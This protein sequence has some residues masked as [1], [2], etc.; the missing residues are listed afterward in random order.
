MFTPPSADLFIPSPTPIQYPV[1]VHSSLGRPVYSFTNSNSVSNPCSLLPRQTCLFLHQLQFSIQS[2]FTPPSADLFIPSPTP[3]QYPVHVHSSLGRPVY[4]FTNSNSVSSPCSLLPR[5]TCLFLHQLQFSIQSIFTP[6]SADLFI[7]SPTPIQYP[8]H[9]QSMFTPPSADLFIPSPT[10]IQYPVHVHSS[11]GRPVYSFT[12]SNSVSSPCSLLP[13]QTC[14]FLHQ[15]QFSIQSM[16]TPP[17]ADLFIPSPTPIQYPVH[18]HS[19]LGRPVYS[20]T[21][22]NSVSSP[23]SLLPRQTC[24]FL[25]QLQFSIQSMFTPPSA[26][27]FIPSPTPIQYPVHVH[28]SLGRPVYSFTNSNSVS[29]PCSL[30]PQQT[31]LFLHQ[32][33][34]SIQSMFTPPSA[35][36]FIPSPTPIQYPVHVHSFLGR[37]VYSFTNSNSVSSP[38]SL[39]PQQTCLFLHQLQFSIQSMFTPPSADLFIPSPTPIQYP[40]HVHFS[41]SRP[42]Y[43]I[44]NSTS[45]SSPC[46][47]LPRQT[48]LFLHQLQFSIQS[49]FTPPSADLFIPSS[50]PFSIQSMF[51]PP[52]ADLFIPSPTPIQYPVHVHLHQLQF[53]IQSMFTPPSADLFI[54]SPT[55]IQYPVH[56]HSSLGRPVYSFTNSNSVS[57]PCSLL[58]QQTCLFHH[59]LHFSIQ[60]MF[61]P[62][63]TDLFIPSPTPIQYPVHVHSS[64]SRPVYSFTNSNSVSS[65]CSLL[66]RQTCLFLHQLQF[67]IQS[68]FTSPSA[69]LFIPSSTPL[70]Y[71]VHVHS[72]LDRPV[73]SFTNSNS[74]SVHVHSSLGRPVYSFTN[75][76][77]VS[78]PCS[79]LPRQTCLFLHQLQFSIQS[80]F[81][82]PSADLFIPSP[83]P[84]QYPVHVHSSL[85]RPV[86]SF[87]NST[88]VSSPCSLLPRQTCL[89]L[90]QLQFSIQSMFTPPSADLFIPSSTPLQY[91]VHVH[92]SLSRHVYSIINSTSVS[93]PCSLLPQQTCLFHYQLHF[94]IQS[95]F[96]P[97]STYLFIPSP[98]PIQY[99]VH[100]HSSLS[101]PV[102]S[103]I[104][105][106]SVSSPCSLLPRQTC[107]FHHQLHFSFAQGC[108]I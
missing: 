17:L 19:S 28:S 60:S 7:P 63:S 107:L 6:P 90:H 5:Q 85:G 41:L 25:H 54:P 20:F 82:P 14:L 26:D 73:Y 43:S 94:S 80:M 69:D 50:T 100:V 103:I 108:L 55:P 57:S 70:Q 2:M 88:S 89:F 58:P 74:V 24:L 96:T 37:P 95:M 83:T 81:T 71:P 45:V 104:N 27:L 68:M 76:N 3:I 23:C 44:I 48:C 64:L 12:N 35:D 101:R 91:P 40:V 52:S 47:L 106:T 86:Y 62:S 31:C 61:T 102:Y 15:L 49:M 78:S 4:S 1:H 51:T 11:L 72:F 33:Q 42:V 29:S 99:P 36:L 67:S 38:C 65:P 21:N 8:V 77:S 84:I 34:F 39:L 53:S 87:T 22:S 18:I 92:S 59:Q 30:L 16:F 56:V 46:S 97:S 75:S 98:T 66:P 32:L 9:V 79:L 10:P 105:S 13:R 93:S